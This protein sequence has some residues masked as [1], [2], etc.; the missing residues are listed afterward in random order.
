MISQVQG[1]GLRIWSDR[2]NLMELVQSLVPGDLRLLE[3]PLTLNPKSLT[4]KPLHPK[5]PKP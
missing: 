2:L 5:T 4:P 3:H 1:W